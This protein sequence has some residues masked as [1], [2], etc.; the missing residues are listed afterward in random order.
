MRFTRDR[1][2]GNE[3][4]FPKSGNRPIILTWRTEANRITLRFEPSA[5][6]ERFTMEFTKTEAKMMGRLL[7]RLTDPGQKGKRLTFR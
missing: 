7:H 3:F 1:V 5:S 4:A 2:G 6:R